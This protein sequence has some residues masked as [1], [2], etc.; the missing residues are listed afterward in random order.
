M[1]TAKAI[2][3]LRES[4]KAYTKEAKKEV[5]RRC[6]LDLTELWCK[7]QQQTMVKI[8]RWQRNNEWAEKMAKDQGSDKNNMYKEDQRIDH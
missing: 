4:I 7:Q 8:Q 5:F 1:S 3:K 2:T 6:E